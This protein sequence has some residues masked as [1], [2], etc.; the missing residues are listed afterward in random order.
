MDILFKN[1]VIGEV[2]NLSYDFSWIYGDFI[3]SENYYLY[4]DFF[5]FLV[6]ED[7][8]EE[9]DFDEELMDEANWFLRDE[10][11]LKDVSFSS[12]KEV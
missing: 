4:K 5:D 3:P 7:D 12:G 9:P 2:S 6:D 10:S 1:Q 11:G 8:S